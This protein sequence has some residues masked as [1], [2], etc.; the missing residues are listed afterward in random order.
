VATKKRIPFLSSKPKVKK[1]QVTIFVGLFAVVG[2][3]VLISAYAAVENW[4]TSILAQAGTVSGNATIVASSGAVGGRA[5]EFKSGVATPTPTPTPTPAPTATPTSGSNFITASGTNLMQ[6]GKAYHSVGFNFSPVGS[7]W[8]SN[9]STAQMDQFFQSV[10]PNSI[11]R[12]FAPPGGTDSVSLV[13]SVVKEADKYNVHLLVSLAVAGVYGQC[14]AAD[15]DSTSSG[16]T[17][18][19]YTDAVK[20]GSPYANWVNSIVKP[21][22]N[23]PGVAMWEIVNEPWH[24][25]ATIAQAGGAAGATTYTNAAA[26]IIRAAETAGAGSAKQLIT[27]G[28]ADI[29]ETGGV[30][31]MESIFKNIDVV[32]DHDYSGDIGGATAYESSEFSELQQIGQALN[33][34]FMV[35]ETGVEAGSNCSSTNIQNAWDNQSAG[36]TLQARINFLLTQKATDYFKGGAASVGFWLYTT[37]GQEES[38]CVYENIDPSDPIMAA[39]KSYVIP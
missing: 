17:A 31:G 6:N 4:G 7:C 8:S 37:P 16:K 28:P 13:Q 34:P 9:W 1:R 18:A 25:G 22:A 33:K 24:G 2:V 3:I 15:S 23:D 21:L 5:V 36:L 29:G 26:A 30:S 14:D 32:D 27:L 10:P 35:D 20:A 11:A 12:F 19:Y 38:G 39:V